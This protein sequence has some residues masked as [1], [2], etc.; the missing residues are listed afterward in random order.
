MVGHGSNCVQ[1]RF[2]DL[3]WRH[4]LLAELQF[5]AKWPQSARKRQCRHH[6]E[7]SW[8]K[9]GCTSVEVWRSEISLNIRHWLSQKNEQ[10]RAQDESR[11]T[12]RRI[13]NSMKIVKYSTCT[14]TTRETWDFSRTQT[15]FKDQ[16]SFTNTKKTFNENTLEVNEN[17]NGGHL[18]LKNSQNS[19]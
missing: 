9:Q 3:C 15:V 7:I 8:P 6:C 2:H 17:V 10:T 1:K 11:G 4:C 13:E 16:T 12:E 14:S 18:L 5:T 19:M